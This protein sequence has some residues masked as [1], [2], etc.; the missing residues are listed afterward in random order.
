M[1]RVTKQALVFSGLAIALLAGGNAHA[2]VVTLA[3]EEMRGL[4]IS[5]VAAPILLDFSAAKDFT[6][7]KQR[8]VAHFSLASLPGTIE[9]ATLNIGLYNIDG[10]GPG[11]ILNLFSFAGD[12][13]VS[14]DEWDVG[15]LVHSFTGIGGEFNMLSLDITALVQAAVAASQPYLGFSFR[16][17]FEGDRYGL[18][19]T[20]GGITE[21]MYGEGPTTITISGVPEP[22]SAALVGLGLVGLALRRR[23]H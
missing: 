11:G 5:G 16:T 23:I 4:H 10:G 18:N 13:T 3:P 7:L 2:S 9:T 14:T 6:S 20:V 21:Y 1:N 8:A 12:G 17:T 19:S 22:G 15:T